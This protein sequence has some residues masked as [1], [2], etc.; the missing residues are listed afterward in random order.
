MLAIK[1]AV[2]AIL[3]GNQNLDS[4]EGLD[5]MLVGWNKIIHN[6]VCM[7]YLTDVRKVNI[8]NDLDK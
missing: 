3:D 6:I 5:E 2:L 8:P 1:N 7:N 4:F